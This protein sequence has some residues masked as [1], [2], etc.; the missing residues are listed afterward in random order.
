MPK[1]NKNLVRSNQNSAAARQNSD[2]IIISFTKNLAA[3]GFTKLPRANKYPR[4]MKLI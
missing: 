4:A 3:S 2:K 1:N